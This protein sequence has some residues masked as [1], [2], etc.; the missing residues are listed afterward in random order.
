MLAR[1]RV[2]REVLTGLI[3]NSLSHTIIYM[4]SKLSRSTILS[5]R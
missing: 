4:I 2:R 5:W 1:G 3:G